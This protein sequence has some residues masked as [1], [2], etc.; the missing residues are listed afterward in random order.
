[1]KYKIISYGNKG[2]I[3]TCQVVAQSGK[4]YRTFHLWFVRGVWVD[5]VGSLHVIDKN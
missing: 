2:S 4:M 3:K 1:M 5:F